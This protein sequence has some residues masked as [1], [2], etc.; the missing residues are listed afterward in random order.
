MTITSQAKLSARYGAPDIAPLEPWN[1]TLDQ[2]LDHRSVRA[3]TDQPLPEGTI[4]T[5][6]AAAQSAS[7]SSNLQVWSV[8]AVQDTERKHRLSALAGNQAYIRQAPLFFV[9]VAD[10]SRVARVA[11]QQGV[12]LEA[13]PYLESLLLGT[14]DAAL[15]AQNAVVALESL[16]LGSVYIGAIRNDIEGVAKELHLPPQVYPVFGLCVGYPSTERTAQVKP[17]LPQRAVLHH[18]T[19]SVASEPEVIAQYDERLGAFYQREGLQ[20][21]GWSEQVINR[22]RNVKNL[23]GREALVEELNRMG[24]GL[25]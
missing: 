15:A 3:F 11:E 10:L 25:R 13:L 19:Y 24:F 22:L 12:K 20:A 4:Q 21:A 1:D 8:V 2:L 6:I 9:W 5:L 23:N 17:R 7:T 16:G 14:I 18:D